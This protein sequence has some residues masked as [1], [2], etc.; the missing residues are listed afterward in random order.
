MKERSKRMITKI[1][2]IKVPHGEVLITGAAGNPALTAAGT[3]N[4]GD[5]SVTCSLIRRSEI[6]TPAAP[7]QI[8]TVTAVGNEWSVDFGAKNAGPYHLACTAPDEP[9][10]EID[11][12]VT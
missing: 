1:N 3:V 4:L 7:A 6:G 5:N 8:I 9:G 10:D 11:I 12:N 2:H